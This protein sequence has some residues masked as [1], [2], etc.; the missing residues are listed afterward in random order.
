MGSLLMV[1]FLGSMTPLAAGT[2]IPTGGPRCEAR[3]FV[4]SVEN[5]FW[6]SP[7]TLVGAPSMSIPR[8]F[9]YTNVSYGASRA[10]EFYV[11]ANHV[12]LTERAARMQEGPVENHRTISLGATARRVLVF[13]AVVALAI[14][15]WQ[16]VD[17]LLLIF[18]GT[19]LAVFFRGL[20]TRL[21]ARTP[22]S[23]GWAL[24]VVALLFVGILVGGSL[25]LGPR[26]SA[27]LSELSQTLPESVDQMKGQLQGTWW[28]QYLLDGSQ[29]SGGGRLRLG[30]DVFGRL[31]G[32][33]SGL[34]SAITNLI[35]I[36]FTAVFFAVDP[37]LYKNGI[38]LLIPEPGAKRV[39]E[40]L[41]ASG[42]ALWKWLMGKLLAM[43]FVGVAVTLGLWIIG[44]P[45]ALVLGLIAGLLDFVPFLGPIV[46]AVPGV[47]LA[48]TLGPTQAVYVVLV[49]F[50]AQQ[51]EGNILTP[52]VQQKEVS[53]PPVLVLFAVIAA[54][55]LFGVLGIIVATPLTVVIMVLTKMLYVEGA[56]G[57]SVE[58]PGGD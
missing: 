47:L 50:I 44:V 14:V 13:I 22:L 21:S 46:A 32:I 33:A 12:R 2:S 29:Q 56:L 11:G 53:L 31:S 43:L 35:L 1:L 7:G 5:E 36:L 51:I 10:I 6:T 45:L 39:R 17:A 16:I 52:L 27:Q 37:R 30:G 41:D 20:A 48:L 15:V 18:M 23:T 19:L 24:V 25:L 57:K 26:V 49:Y 4:G 42:R 58:I 55:L 9:V 40:S 3:Q 54:G 34:M 8:V 28:G 38:V